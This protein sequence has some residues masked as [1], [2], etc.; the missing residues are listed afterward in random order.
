MKRN[1]KGETGGENSKVGGKPGGPGGLEGEGRSF[2][3]KSELCQ[4]R[5]S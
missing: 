5:H 1:K 2:K 4:V 3:D